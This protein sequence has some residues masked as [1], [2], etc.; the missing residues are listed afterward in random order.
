MRPEIACPQYAVWVKYI[1]KPALKIR[2]LSYRAAKRIFPP[3]YQ[4]SLLTCSVKPVLMPGHHAA[5]HLLNV[6]A[7]H[8]SGNAV[9]RHRAYIHMHTAH[10]IYPFQWIYRSPQNPQT[11]I[12]IT[13]I[14]AC[15]AY[16]LYRPR[17]KKI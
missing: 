5:H 11:T 4:V 13:Y 8:K 2:Q 10:K 14:T 15:S 6:H 1:K 12:Y 16:L 3:V 9:S 17:N 7:G